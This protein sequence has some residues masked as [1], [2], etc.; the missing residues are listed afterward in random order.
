MQQ[1]SIDSVDPLAGEESF[2][3]QL[4][5]PIEDLEVEASLV[6]KIDSYVE[7]ILAASQLD[8]GRYAQLG[9]LTWTIVC[10]RFDVSEVDALISDINQSLFPQDSEQYLEVQK[11]SSLVEDQWSLPK[12]ADGFRSVPVEAAMDDEADFDLDAAMLE[13]TG[14]GSSGGFASDPQPEIDLSDD[15]Y[16]SLPEARVRQNGGTILQPTPRIETDADEIDLD[17]FG[18][19]DQGRLPRSIEINLDSMLEPPT[20][21]V[22]DVASELA[23][24]RDEMRQIASG[25]PDRSSQD[26]VG[27]FREEMENL[28]GT[29]GQRMD[30]AA[31]R[32]EAAAQSITDVSKSFSGDKLSE[33]SEK[34]E[35]S[36]QILDTTVREA[37]TALQSILELKAQLVSQESD[38]NQAAETQ[39]TAEPV[40]VKG[41]SGELDPDPIDQSDT[42]IIDDVAP[43]PIDEIQNIQP[44]EDKSADFEID[45]DDES[46]WEINEARI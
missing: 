41:Q 4:R 5:P 12:D 32:V 34:A 37:V 15:V 22:T 45:L 13:R 9:P 44:V 43:D 38:P 29:L 11:P 8:R 24:F 36:A 23:S 21:K 27:N 19:A 2:I 10:H 1:V 18:A 30:G 35:Q 28:T 46:E 7:M 39:E 14:S 3:V 33:V 25:I 40:N 26:V 20:P 16:L 42:F 6:E 31:Q 17:D